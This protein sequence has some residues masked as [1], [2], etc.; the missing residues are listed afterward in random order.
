MRKTLLVVIIIVIVGLVSWL[1]YSSVRKLEQKEIRM[2]IIS[3]IPS[4]SFQDLNGNPVQLN[5]ITFAKPMVLILFNS[6]CEYC[7][8]EA[9]S[10]SENIDQLDEAMIVFL[11]AEEIDVIRSFGET[12]GLLEH[13]NILCGQVDYPEL[14]AVFKSVSYPNIFIYGNDGRLVKE[15]RGETKVEA[16]LNAVK[17]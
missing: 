13:A 17:N 3:S 12:Y 15:F 6:E 8:Y 11:S 14:T 7:R 2:E 4:L 9:M 1:V 5:E 10:I 16:I